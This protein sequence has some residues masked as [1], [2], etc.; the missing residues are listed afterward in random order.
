MAEKLAE[1]PGR[2]GRTDDLAD[3]KHAVFDEDCGRGEA[4][5][6]HGKLFD[7]VAAAGRSTIRHRWPGLAD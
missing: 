3:L 1:I 7:K 6:A 2:L 5:D 4:L